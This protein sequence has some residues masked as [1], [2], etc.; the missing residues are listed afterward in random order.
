MP[1]RLF[2]LLCV[3]L[4]SFVPVNAQENDRPPVTCPTSQALVSG[5]QEIFLTVGEIARR[6]LVYIPESYDPTVPT[7]L[8]LS[9]HGFASNPNQQR[10][11]SSWDAVADEHGFIVAYPQG[12]GFPLRWNSGPLSFG[13]SPIDDVAFVSALIDDLAQSLCIDTARVYV[14]GLSN[15]GG[16]SHRLACELS[17]RITAMGGVA[18]YYTFE[19]CEPTRPVP[20]MAFHGDR[21]A[22]VPIDGMAG[23]VGSVAPIADWVAGWAERN[24]CQTTETLETVGTVR[25]T[26][27]T[28]CSEDADVVYYV[29]GGGGHTWPGESEQPE[30]ISGMVNRDI[31]AS[32]L[33]W[34]FFSQYALPR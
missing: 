28:D 14:N 25:G 19:T 18:G 8:V 7:P 16:I 34:D 11:F 12:T 1:I 21:D 3:A 24:A 2:V 26:R 9:F 15:G 4:L 30:F 5:E 17:D 29:V 6:A 22:I 13:D 32:V 23:G 31:D 10:V 33:M 20:V 27:Y